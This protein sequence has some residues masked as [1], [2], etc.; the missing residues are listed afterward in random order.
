M[1]VCLSAAAFAQ[2]DVLIHSHN[3]YERIAP[4][5]QA[6]AQKVTSIECDMYHMGGGRFYVS[7]NLEDARPEINFDNT[8]CEPIIRAYML[9]GGHAWADDPQRPLQLLIDIKSADPDAFLKALVRKLKR[10]PELFDRRVNPLACQVVITGNRPEPSEWYR[11]PSFIMFD[12]LI[13]KDYTPDQL[14]RVALVSECFGDYSKWKGEGS[15][16]ADE[17]AALRKVIDKAHAWGKPIRFWGCPDN[18]TTWRTWIDMG[19]DYLNT[20]HPERCRG[21]LDGW[22]DKL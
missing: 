2:N 8:Y 10:H 13:D 20:D 7:H 1:A 21:Y 9:N 16:A 6:Y 18:V 11:Y 14:A 3:D 12:G 5:Y 4:F 17:E 15:I 22:S 19:I